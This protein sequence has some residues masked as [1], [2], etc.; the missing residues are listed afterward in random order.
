MTAGFGLEKLGLVS[1]RYPWLCLALA[2]L[3]TPV[4]AYGARHL[5]FSSDIREIFRSGDP[6]FDLL[7]V[8]DERFPDIQR[9]I[10]VVVSSDKPFDLEELKT[11][12]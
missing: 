9:D 6:A 10:H 3:I 2:V 4:M 11:L 5:D 1:L 12:K 8:V 7:D